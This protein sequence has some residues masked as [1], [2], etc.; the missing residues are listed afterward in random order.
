MDPV[1]TTPLISGEAPA[2]NEE[3][4]MQIQNL[5][6]KI[7]VL[8]GKLKSSTN[9]APSATPIGAAPDATT[10]TIDDATDGL[11]KS[12]SLFCTLWGGPIMPSED[13]SLW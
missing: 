6:Q 10:V 4:Q 11:K 9:E 13:Q 5:Q 1:I 7:A 2:N 8:E 12:N 3:I